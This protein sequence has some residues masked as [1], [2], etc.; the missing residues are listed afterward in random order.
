[1]TEE[2]EGVETRTCAD[3]STHVETRII[4][5]LPHTHALTRHDAVGATCTEAGTIEYWECTTCGELFFDEEGSQQ[6]TAYDIAVAATGHAWGAWE[7]TTPATEEAEGVEARFCANDPTHTETR[8]IPVATHEHALTKVDAVAPTCT[9]AGNV[10]YWVCS[11]EDGCG[12]YFSNEN[13]TGELDS[14]ELVVVATGH[15]WGEG[16]E[17]PQAT[18]TTKGVRTY[19]CQND[20]CG[21]TKTES[22]PSLGHAWDEGQLTTKPTCMGNGVMTYTCANDPTHTR[23]EPVDALGHVWDGGEVTTDPT[24][25]AK[26]VR[27]LRCTR[28]ETHTRQESVDATGHAWDEG[29]VTTDPTCTAKGVRTF[30]CANDPTH[31]RTEPVGATGHDWGEPTYAW[32]SDL[33]SV[34]AKRVCKN[35]PEHVQ[36]ETAKA[37]SQTTKAATCTAKGTKAYTA[38]FSNAAFGTQTKKVSVAALGHTWGKVTYSWSKDLSACTAKR[39]CQNDPGHVQK[40][41]AQV[42][43]KVTKKATATTAGVRTYTAAFDAA[44]AK[45]QTKS[46]AIDPTGSPVVKANAHVQGVGWL[47]KVAAD[48]MVGTVGHSHRLEAFDLTLAS[49]P[50]S[51]GIEYMSHVQGIGWEKSW[52][53]DGQMSGTSGQ[54]KRVEATRIRLYGNMAKKYDVYYR[55]HAQNYGWMGWA[56]NGAKAGTQGKSL[57]I[58]AMQVVLVKKGAP[59]PT[60]VFKGITQSYSKAFVK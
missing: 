5:V 55:V 54:S 30:T 32:A 8:V 43:S 2:A 22:T 29:V 36:T 59:A 9:Q 42:S 49:A 10:E 38:A 60:A 19:A 16:V 44:W 40:A 48:K 11:G 7:V 13:A 6:I 35:D 26:G 33:G 56:K 50:A 12:R 3:D 18:C 24:C 25:T 20:G 34:T 45:K 41:K 31:T 57:R 46:A 21:A 39:V 58:E 17:M 53:R 15:S 37:T 23:T 14:T 52:S 47:N 51:G 27:T 1:A 4:D 28:D